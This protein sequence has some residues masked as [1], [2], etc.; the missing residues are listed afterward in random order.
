MYIDDRNITALEPEQD[1]TTQY[2]VKASVTAEDIKDVVVVGSGPAGLS[3]ALYTS[4]AGLSTFVVK[5]LTAGGLV[6]STEEIDNYLGIPGVSGIDMSEKFLEHSQ[7]F[8]AQMV[9]GVVDRII[10]RDDS[11]FETHLSDTGEVLLSRS[12][13]FAAG[14]EPRKLSVPGSELSGVS[15]CATCDGMFFADENVAVVGGGESAVEEASYLANLCS[16]VDVFVRSSWRASKP[17]VE[18]LETLSNVFV[19][20]GVNV[21]EIQDSGSGE[22]S[23]VVGTD[24]ATYPVSG[25]F[26]AVGQIPNSRAA[27]GNVELFSDGFIHR[28]TVDGFFVAGDVSD[29]DF[30]QVAVAVGSGAKAGISATRF[31]L[32]D[33]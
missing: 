22:V 6:T 31:V 20:E 12:V 15:Y 25:V 28:S 33:K 30:R 2:P 21:A 10:K 24:G 26:V 27:E 5:G 11:V 14:S 18:R 9:D 7:M 1:I 17:A 3:A 13:V 8:G 4:R 16:R 32:S 29:P 19:H 23:G